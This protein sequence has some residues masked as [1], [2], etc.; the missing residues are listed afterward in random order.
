MFRATNILD[1]RVIECEGGLAMGL[2]LGVC[3]QHVGFLA[4][5]KKTSSV[6]KVERL[7][8]VHAKR[9]REL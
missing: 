9:M 4:D 7:E 8:R 5:G 2:E 3:A 1:G 6:W